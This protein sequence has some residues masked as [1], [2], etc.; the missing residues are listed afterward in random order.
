MFFFFRS[1]SG[2]Q[3][4]VCA[5]RDAPYLAMGLTVSETV[6]AATV[7]GSKDTQSQLGIGISNGFSRVAPS[8][9]MTMDWTF[10]LVQNILPN[11]EVERTVGEVFPFARQVCRNVFELSWE[12][13]WSA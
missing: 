1:C 13:L 4:W 10:D 2:S 5:L 9:W 7:L 12:K 3:Q 6:V 11:A 8:L